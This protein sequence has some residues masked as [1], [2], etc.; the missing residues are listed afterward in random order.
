MFSKMKSFV[1]L[2]EHQARQIAEFQD[3]LEIKINNILDGVSESN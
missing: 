1:D 3:K 2:H